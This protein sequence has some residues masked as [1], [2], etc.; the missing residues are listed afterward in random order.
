MAELDVNLIDGL[1]ALV[2]LTAF[3][4]VATGR[5]RTLVRVF[6]LQSLALGL[7]AA[8][9]AYSTGYWHIY[10]VAA[11]TILLKALVI[12]RIIDRVMDRIQVAN[13]VEPSVRTPSSLLIAGGLAILAYYVAEPLIQSGETITAGALALSLAVVLIGLFVMISRKKAITQVIGLL[14]MENGLFMAALSLSYGMPLIVEL[15]VFFDIMVAVLI[16]GVFVFRINRTFDTL[17]T[18]FL[19][20]LRD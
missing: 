12:P 2:L 16:M 8:A 9:V 4:I 15:G 17:D 11:L 5:M 6:A 19:R 14:V 3:L 18:S 20:R 10:I 7:L 1:A 13:D